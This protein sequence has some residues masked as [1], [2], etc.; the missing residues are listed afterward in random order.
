MRL[1]DRKLK[2]KEKK[3][4]PKMKYKS[5]LAFGVKDTKENKIRWINGEAIDLMLEVI[6]AEEKEQLNIKHDQVINKIDTKF[7]VEQEKSQD[8]FLEQYYKDTQ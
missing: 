2:K 5:L 4:Q 3:E 6:E 1:K 8:D 7:L